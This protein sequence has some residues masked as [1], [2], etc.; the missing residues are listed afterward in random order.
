MKFTAG[1]GFSCPRLVSRNWFDPEK[2]VRERPELPGSPTGP[3]PSL[4]DTFRRAVNEARGNL[5]EQGMSESEI[6]DEL[7]LAK[8]DEPDEED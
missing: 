4:R 6:D 1:T 2:R 8:P 3:K 5:R 7:N